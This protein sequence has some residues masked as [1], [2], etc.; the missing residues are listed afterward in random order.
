MT[1]EPARQLCLGVVGPL[2][3]RLAG[4]RLITQ[5][6]TARGQCDDVPD[7]APTALELVRNAEFIRCVVG[8]DIGGAS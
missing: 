2:R 1:R 4:K 3:D 7:V 8:R 6:K 5:E